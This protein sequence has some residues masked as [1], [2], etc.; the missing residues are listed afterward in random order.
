M[1]RDA[2]CAETEHA[3]N[4]MKQPNVIR[5]EDLVVPA[6]AAATQWSCADANGESGHAVNS[7]FMGDSRNEKRETMQP[8]G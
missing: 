3:A 8:L 6:W 5:R 4:A 7:D 1:G 2:T